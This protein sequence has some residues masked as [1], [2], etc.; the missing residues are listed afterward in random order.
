MLTES[1]ISSSSAPP[2]LT[3]NTNANL[4]DAGIFV[5]TYQPQPALK[6]TFKKSATEPCCLALNSSHIF[7]A[8]KGKAVIH[9]YNREK[10]N[11]EATVPFPERICSITLIANGTIV[12]LGLEGGG[13]LLW[14][15]MTGRIV[16]TTQAHLQSVNAVVSD[17][18]SN[19]LLSGSEDSTVLVWSLV[20]L[21]SFSQGSTLGDENRKPRHTLSAHKSAITA[22]VVGHSATTANIAVSASKDRNAIVW[23]YQTG[24]MLRRFLLPSIPL[25]LALDPAD[26]A[27]YAGNEDGS[28]QFVDFYTGS[29]QTAI[30]STHDTSFASTPVQPPASSRWKRPSGS[31]Q[32]AALSLALCFDGTKILSGHQSGKIVAWD[33]SNATI[34]GNLAEHT[35]APITNIQFL[36]PEGFPHVPQ[37]EITLG[38]L[39]KP[40]QHEAFS[41]PGGGDLA[42]SYTIASHVTARTA[43]EHR[44]KTAFESALD[45]IGFDMER[46][47]ESR[48]ALMKP[49]A[50]PLTNG[51]DP[52]SDFMA[53]DDDD[54]D[55][56]SNL[57]SK[58]NEALREKVAHL[59]KLQ[60]Q[61]FELVAGL[62]QERDLLQ[63]RERAADLRKAEE[64][65]RRQR[66]ADEGWNAIGKT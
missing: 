38:R 25:C 28:L 58:E 37:N 14:E 46:L 54:E 53:L 62:T 51:H 4:K 61:S 15:L 1:F 63:E 30:A 56:S 48:A 39:V 5:H 20:D 24:E 23:N 17:I 35:G 11:Q 43:H 9:V 29:S 10:G 47:D 7:A 21:L 41:G 66:V 31:D 22:L 34:A 42:A 50:A 8:Q 32:D 27:V 6:S 60:R 36:Q 59:E 52:E 55:A 57:H 2:T 49:S 19:F 64:L 13:I 18:T 44:A 33:V 16:T 3:S 26:R 65:R 40:R 12:V 45:S